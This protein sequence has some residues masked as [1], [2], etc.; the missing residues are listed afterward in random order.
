MSAAAEP[1][2]RTRRERINTRLTTLPQPWQI[3]RHKPGLDIAALH[4]VAIEEYP[5]QNGPADY[6]LVVNGKVAGIVEAKKVSVGA[7]N[8]LEQAKRYAMG[9][10]EGAGKW[11][12]Y[13]V[14]FLYSTNGEMVYHI[15]VRN[16]QSLSR[17]ISSFHT[18]TALAEWLARGEQDTVTLPRPSEQFPRVR[19]YQEKAILAVE[20]AI[21]DGK[22]AFLVAMATGTGKTYTTVAQI[23]R[24][25]ESKKVRRVL[26]LVDRRALAAQAVREFSSFTTPTG[27]KFDQ[28]YEV[29]S[30]QF[31]REDL[32]DDLPWNVK[33]LPAAYLTDPQASHTF[34]YV[35]TIQR[36][37]INL[38]GWQNAF[39][40]SE[41]DPDYED[42]T[43]QFDIPIHAFDLMIADE[44]HRGYTAKQTAVWRQVMDHFDA[45]KMGLTATPAAHTLS[46]FHEVV[47]RYSTQ[48]AIDDGF[49]VDYEAVKIRSNVLMDGAFLR[50]GE[51]VGVVDTTT[52]RES[53]DQ[54]ED[55]REFASTEIE[56]KITVPETNRKIILE[57]KK[58]T[59]RFEKAF[60]HFPKTLIFASN[61]LPHTSH[62]DTLVAMCREVFAQGDDFVKKITGNANVDRPLQRIREFRNR[63][64]PKIVVSVDMLSTGV[65]IPALEFIVFLR[66]VKS[67]ILWVQ[68]L[69][70]GTRRCDEIAKECFTIFD[71]FDGG[72]I[73]YFKGVTDFD[74]ELS[75][76]EPVS[77]AQVIENIYQN[78]D[79]EYYTN[80]LVRRLRRIE[81]T[82]SAEAREEFAVYIPDGDIGRFAGELRQKLKDQFTET[83]AL[84]RDKRFQELLLSYKRAAR[85]FIK[86]Y[87]TQDEVT[88]E[89]LVREERSQDYIE[90]FERF[91]AEHRTD[92]DA[93]AIL[94][95]RPK[96]WGTQ[97]LE[98]LRNKLRENRF[99]EKDLVAAHNA[100]YGRELVDIIS[101]VK[102]AASH[103]E[104]LLSA[105]ERVDHAVKAVSAGRTFTADQQKWL[106]FIRA[107]LVQNL[108]IDAGDFDLQPV[109]HDRGGRRKAEKVFGKQFGPLLQ[110]LNRAVAA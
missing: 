108:T 67:R 34:V 9:C 43:S 50:E 36:M 91:V 2:W 5:T 98:E 28:E 20:N 97:A 77:L 96:D 72:L 46:L 22:R 105:E 30:Q 60:G 101:M 102:H 65:D 35:C 26:F 40:Q 31:R 23:Y 55:E 13:R 83:M 52:G 49:L 48:Q 103:A 74:V 42:E 93:L 17:P 76:N 99:R 45:I 47:Y 51:S 41:S 78:I 12:Q 106:D 1:E 57:L 81:R 90:A 100:V 95:S 84:L 39:Q 73:E 38:L 69:G 14:P 24:L 82:M 80:V 110:E 94:L 85:T 87:E 25:L 89:F 8:V 11:G 79:R 68:M 92:V 4:G 7:Q 15:D 63:P 33:T 104:P 109:L 64:L 3:L 29:F 16:P 32:E 21:E 56:H 27:R 58:Y 44:C 6:A 10:T 62:A 86:A 53:Y 59:D 70:R 88:S 75:E 107:H 37:A 18:P 54:L 66:P 61:D 19:E 71:C